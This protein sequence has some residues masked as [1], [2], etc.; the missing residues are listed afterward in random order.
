ML[1]PS[2]YM[3]SS[4]VCHCPDTKNLIENVILDVFDPPTVQYSR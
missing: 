4:S 2:L 3:A 1:N